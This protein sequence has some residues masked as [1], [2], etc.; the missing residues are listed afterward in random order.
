MATQVRDVWSV[1]ASPPFQNVA[2]T[3]KLQRFRTESLLRRPD[4]V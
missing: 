3:V 4:V 1:A 2:G